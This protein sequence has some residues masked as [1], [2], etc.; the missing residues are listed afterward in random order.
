M[1]VLVYSLIGAMAAVSALVAYLRH[2]R[3]DLVPAQMLTAAWASG[4]AVGAYFLG[5]PRVE[6]VMLGVVV[7]AAFAALWT[8]RRQQS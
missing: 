7:V 1:P 2:P 3:V 8:I 4:L 5:L 6:M